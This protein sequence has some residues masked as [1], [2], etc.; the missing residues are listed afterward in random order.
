MSVL[1]DECLP[2]AA[3]AAARDA[4]HDARHVIDLGCAVRPTAW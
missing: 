2:T 4:G 1:L 3:A